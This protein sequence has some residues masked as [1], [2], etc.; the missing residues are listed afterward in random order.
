MNAAHGPFI[1]S[2]DNSTTHPRTLLVSHSPR[3]PPPNVS[4]TNLFSPLI[5]PSPSPSQASP[6]GET[7]RS[8]LGGV[9]D[10]EWEDTKAS[11]DVR[12]EL[13]RKH[14]GRCS[15]FCPA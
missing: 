13:L 2:I 8:V 14:I 7:K 9:L 4:F 12:I 5:S 6:L 11:I 3:S 1:R 15:S 10:T